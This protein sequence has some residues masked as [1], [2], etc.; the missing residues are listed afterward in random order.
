[1]RLHETPFLHAAATARISSNC[2]NGSLSKKSSENSKWQTKW[3]VLFK[4]LMFYYERENSTRP[5]GVVLLEGTTC[6][7]AVMHDDGK[8]FAFTIA[9]TNDK[10]PLIFASETESDCLVWITSITQSSMLR[11]EKDC[12]E[13]QVKL[14]EV[15]KRLQTEQA[16]KM[17]Y[18]T[19]TEEQ[20][21]TIKRL[22]D[23]NFKLKKH[24]EELKMEKYKSSS[25]NGT[26]KN[27]EE[28]RLNALVSSVA[29]RWYNLTRW[30]K[31]IDMYVKSEHADSMK[32]RNRVLW[33]LM[34]SEEDYVSQLGTLV[35]CFY[36]PLKMA[37]SSSHPPLSH[38]QLNLIFRNCETLFYIHQIFLQGLQV[39][40]E[41][42][43]VL[44][45]GDLFDMLLPLLVVYQ[46]FVRN[47]A[48]SLEVLTQCKHNHNFY[49]L[50]EKHENKPAAYGYSLEMYLTFPIQRIPG[51]VTLLNQLLAF[52]PPDHV[53]RVKFE[54]ARS[55]LQELSVVIYEQTSDSE[56]MY[57]TL[58]I[59]KMI[60][61]G[62]HVLF[63]TN[64][65]F[66]RQGMLRLAA[67]S[68]KNTV[69]KDVKLGPKHCF[70][71]TNHM[72]IT[73]RIG[74][75]LSVNK[76]YGLVALNHCILIEEF[77]EEDTPDR[78]HQEV[79]FR[80]TLLDS[81]PDPRTIT[82]VA[83]CPRDK[84]SWTVDIS[85]CIENLQSETSSHSCYG[86]SSL[87]NDPRSD[88]RLF[89]DG[90][91]IKYS[92]RMNSGQT[93]KVR[94]ASLDK[95]LERLMDARF[96]GVEYLNTF[97]LT[98]RCFTDGHTV[99]GYI[100]NTYYDA[101]AKLPDNGVPESPSYL[102]KNNIFEK[103]SPPPRHSLTSIGSESVFMAAKYYSEVAM[104]VFN[105]IKSWISKYYQDFVSDPSLHQRLMIFLD[106]VASNESNMT[107]CGRK[108]V[109]IIHR[110]LALQEAS[111]AAYP[112]GEIYNH[113]FNKSG[114]YSCLSSLAVDCEVM[115]QQ[116][117][118]LEHWALT[119]IAPNEFLDKSWVKD[120]ERAPH[121]CSIMQRCDKMSN[122][123]ASEVLSGE[124][125]STRA[126]TITRWI[127]VATLCRKYN[128]FASLLQVVAGLTFSAI[129]RL[130]YTWCIVPQEIKAELNALKEVVSVANRFKNMKAG[131][132]RCDPP[133]V[134][135]VGV[136]LAD[137]ISIEEGVQNLNSNG[138]I[139][140]AKMRM[141][142]HTILE[143]RLYQQTYYDL[144]V[145]PDVVK[146]ILVNCSNALCEDKIFER[147]YTLEPRN[148]RSPTIDHGA[149]CA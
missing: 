111:S 24:I 28:E 86:R 98:Y 110:S 119:E 46:D 134:P 6:Q 54:E 36:K 121:I 78:T 37:A 40:M 10:Q 149:S 23:E 71:F 91:T 35:M 123:V 19:F 88:P 72:L 4:N 69:R 96:L 61:G 113:Y 95:L 94:Y 76:E 67:V 131:I 27:S 140:F 11:V 21:I 1:M 57:K 53:E 115:A 84:A 32:K 137:L 82:L 51:Y 103:H 29:H 2:Q 127:N 55:K 132:K 87:S 124:T 26:A 100:I 148:Q 45:L 63:D 139:N 125:A 48:S 102:P 146:H 43:P 41:K 73:E 64:Q 44:V 135:Y 5:S 66:V 39:R 144:K 56:S 52:T 25:E 133:C 142:A 101:L 83:E 105:V 47:H 9:V 31:I 14:Q 130:K 114:D 70:L 108:A 117:T 99:L 89:A 92:L 8:Q 85:Q 116:L 42:W 58:S 16:T 145:V 22:R 80:M 3:C 18:Q 49:T 128:N 118:I 50:L 74:E 17:E 122:M 129:Q 97:L 79:G 65:H 15:Q 136:Y 60:S 106:Q 7:R 38:A 143:I 12:V 77:C 62:C 107:Q 33:Q 59:E 104:R 138:L 109:N 81:S 120:K 75:Q 112:I 20:V 34:K 147:S 90:A 68:S 126:K 93:P 13:L 30:R 141:L